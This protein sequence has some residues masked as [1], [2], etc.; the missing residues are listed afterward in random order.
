MKS[1]QSNRPPR[2]TSTEPKKTTPTPMPQRLQH[3]TNPTPPR[4]PPYTLSAVE[5]NR[6][7]PILSDGLGRR[8]DKPLHVDRGLLLVRNKRLC[9]QLYLKGYCPGC[10]KDHSWPWP[11]GT[12]DY[13]NL[14]LSARQD[15]CPRADC[16]SPT[17]VFG[18]KPKPFVGMLE[19]IKYLLGASVSERSMS[20]SVMLICE[21]DKAVESEHDNASIHENTLH[22]LLI[23]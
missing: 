16:H 17:C 23:H 12:H 6:L 7:R 21:E 15:P 1:T 8:I 13:D 20:R 5:F 10:G 11:L 19:Y 4:G 22:P 9:P 14:W 2:S 3:H 18:H